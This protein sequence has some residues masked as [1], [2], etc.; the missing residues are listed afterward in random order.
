MVIWIIV[1]CLL[2]F[3]LGALVN[4]D[5]FFALCGH[6]RFNRR[7]SIYFMEEL[8][9]FAGKHLLLK[10]LPQPYNLECA[11]AFFLQEIITKYISEN[12][13]V[14]LS[15]AI[16][17]WLETTHIEYREGKENEQDDKLMLFK[18]KIKAELKVRYSSIAVGA[19]DS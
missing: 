13:Q 3:L 11:S 17:N 12:M 18:D 6:D 9:S 1:M 10:L 19:Y 2:W 14:L 8:Y 4:S 5:S 7:P 16:E 15:V